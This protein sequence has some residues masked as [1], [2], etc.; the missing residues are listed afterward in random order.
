MPNLRIDGSANHFHRPDHDVP[1]AWLTAAA[2]V[3]IIVTVISVLPE[4]PLRL[5]GEASG[6]GYQHDGIGDRGA[7]AC[8]TKGPS[9]NIGWCAVAVAMT[10]AQ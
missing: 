1:G 10:A 2:A 9:P 6:Y 8:T 4:R 7:L 5:S 3:A